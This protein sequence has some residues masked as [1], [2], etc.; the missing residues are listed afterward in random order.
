MAPRNIRRMTRNT[1]GDLQSE[2]ARLLW[3]L[4]ARAGSQAAF[5]RLH[6]I[7][8]A[9][10]S[11][12][13]YCERRPD[14]ESSIKLEDVG[15]PMRTWGQAPTSPIVPLGAQAEDPTDVAPDVPERVGIDRSADYDQTGTGD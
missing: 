8:T 3:E 1:L 4:V 6:D 14:R 5:A 15:I 13:L 9:S 12:W 2:G 10:L 7:D 11:R